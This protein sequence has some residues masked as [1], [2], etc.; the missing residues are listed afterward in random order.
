MSRK[1]QHGTEQAAALPMASAP[2]TFSQ[3]SITPNLLTNQ[4]KQ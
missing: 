2:V 1:R 4:T 3:V